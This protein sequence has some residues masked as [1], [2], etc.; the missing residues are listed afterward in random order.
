MSATTRALVAPLSLYSSTPRGIPGNSLAIVDGVLHSDG[1]GVLVSLRPRATAR[2]HTIVTMPEESP[3]R[4]R[5]MPAASNST[6]YA[7]V[8]ILST[9]IRLG[10]RIQCNKRSSHLCGTWKGSS[11]S[12]P[13][14]KE[15]E[16]KFHSK[17]SKL[18]QF[19]P[20]PNSLRQIHTFFLGTFG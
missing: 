5:S 18:S 20:G 4:I 19:P 15:N 8:S 2:E 17:T 13:T 16:H 9:L 14:E 6:P 3:T 11:G 12:S 7:I 1:E 10:S